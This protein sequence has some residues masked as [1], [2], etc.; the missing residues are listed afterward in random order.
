MGDYKEMV[1][2]HK[3]VFIAIAF[4]VV[5]VVVGS[6]VRCSVVNFSEP[7]VADETAQQQEQAVNEEEQEAVQESG[8]SEQEE[9]IV[10]GYSE[11]TLDFIA[12]LSANVWTASN[13]TMSLTFEETAFTESKASEDVT[14]G[15]VVT[16]VRTTQLPIAGQ[17]VTQHIAAVQIEGKPYILE[18]QQAVG[19][20]GKGDVFSIACDA[21]ANSAAYSRSYASSSFVVEGINEDFDVVFK[22]KTEELENQLHEYCSQ[23]YPTATEAVWSGKFEMDYQKNVVKTSFHLD[24]KSSATVNVSFDTQELAFDIAKVH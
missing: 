3:G 8:L 16:A 20:D 24:N 14:R 18:V 6:M 21:F 1:M 11:E 17:T 23:Y 5:A 9:R 13:E 4:V 10:I 22:G 12:L 15:F 7:E 2:N 19:Q